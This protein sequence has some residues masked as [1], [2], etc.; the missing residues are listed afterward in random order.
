MTLKDQI[1]E[2]SFKRLDSETDNERAAKMLEA[3]ATTATCVFDDGTAHGR[4]I[5]EN[6]KE[7]FQKTECPVLKELYRRAA[8]S[9]ADKSKVYYSP[10]SEWSMYVLRNIGSI[11]GSLQKIEAD[12]YV[13]QKFPNQPPEDFPLKNNTVKVDFN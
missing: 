4:L 7:R 1:I 6:I 11:Y 2:N 13:P 3:I 5:P 9:G 10:D 8:L 12:R